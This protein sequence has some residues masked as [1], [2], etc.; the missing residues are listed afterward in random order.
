MSE[1]LFFIT[2][3]DIESGA[4]TYLA[5]DTEL[6]LS[7]KQSDAKL[8]RSQ[9]EVDGLLRRLRDEKLV[10]ETN[11]PDRLGPLTRLLCR[12]GAA[13]KKGAV[14]VIVQQL[15]P[16]PLHGFSLQA[17]EEVFRPQE[18]WVSASRTVS[19]IQD[20]TANEHSV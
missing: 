11:R 6:Y 20:I 15:T 1:G 5:Q 17:I 16:Q 4:V 2:V 9:E 8:F 19:P 12:I 10:Q 7:Q 18:L 13:N 3:K 14:Q